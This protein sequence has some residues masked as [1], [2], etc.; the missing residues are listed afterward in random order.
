[1][2]IV[3]PKREDYNNRKEYFW[4][5]QSL[6]AMNKT[7]N[8]VQT[9]IALLALYDVKEREIISSDQFKK[10]VLA[11]ENFHFAFTAICSLRTNTIIRETH[12]KNMYWKPHILTG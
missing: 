9:R 11:M 8:I 2:K 6:N 1:M 7:F 12:I 10:A 3:N 4:L 5:I